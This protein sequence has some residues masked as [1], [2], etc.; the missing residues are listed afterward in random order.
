MNDVYDERID[1]FGSQSS[2]AAVHSRLTDDTS[3]PSPIDV[4]M[5]R[6]EDLLRSC[7]DLEDTPSCLLDDVLF[8]DETVPEIDLPDDFSEM[9][10]FLRILKFSSIVAP[11]LV[12]SAVQDGFAPDVQDV[13]AQL[14]KAS[15]GPELINGRFVIK[16]A[17]GRG[18]YGIVHRAFDLVTQREVALK[19]PRPELR[20]IRYVME[21]FY[22]E[23]TSVGRIVHPG[24]VPLLD[25]GLYEGTPYLVTRLVNGLNLE[26]WLDQANAPVPFEL[27]ALWGEQLAEA[28]DHLHKR[29][30]IHGD[31]KPS[32]ILLEHPYDEE[33]IELPP[34][35]L[36]VRVTDFG[37]ASSTSR[38]ADEPIR[39][40]QGTLSYMAPEQLDTQFRSDERSD[41]YSICVILFELITGR[42]LFD[43]SETNAIREAIR[44]E[45]PP[46]PRS[47]RPDTPYALQTI[48]T[49]G[50]SKRPEDRYASAG[51]LARDLNAW[52]NVRTPEVL[53]NHSGRRFALWLRR[54]RGM[55]SVVSLA[56]L[57]MS[58]LLG[59]SLYTSR[60][61]FHYALKSD[62]AAWWSRYVDQIQIA[63]TFLDGNDPG[64][65]R[66]ILEKL[67]RWPA[68]L[69]RDDDP[70]EFAWFH[71]DLLWRD[72]SRPVPGVPAGVWHLA[73]ATDA[74]SGMVY[75]GGSDGVLRKVD[76]SNNLVVG[77]RSVQKD[78][79]RV[80]AVSPDGRWIAVAGAQGAIRILEAATM[81]LS[82]E[83][84]A[85]AKE[86]TDMA[87]GEDS[88][89]LFSCALDGTLVT[90]E[91]ESGSFRRFDSEPWA[92]NDDD[93]PAMF[94][95]AILPGGK[96]IAVG[97]ADHRIQIY[98]VAKNGPGRALVGH[99]GEVH[100]VRVS[101]DGKWLIST[102]QDRYIAFW[103]IESLE[104]K[105]QVEVGDKFRYVKPPIEKFTD[106]R[107][108]RAMSVITDSDGLNAVAVDVAEGHVKLFQIPTGACLGQLTRPSSHAIALAWLPASSRMVVADSSPELRVWSP[109][110]VEQTIEAVSFEFGR[111]GDPDQYLLSASRDSRETWDGG[112]SVRYVPFDKNS[113][114]IDRTAAAANRSIWGS[115]S[116]RT[117]EDRSKGFVTFL[118]ARPDAFG[119]GRESII[120]WKFVHEHEVT[121]RQF[122]PVLK[123]HPTRPYFLILDS[124]GRI[125]VIDFTDFE[126]PKI[127]ETLCKADY[128]TFRPDSDE[129]LVVSD[130]RKEI[131][132]WN[133]MTE[134][135]TRS[136]I[137]RTDQDSRIVMAEF[138]RDPNRLIVAYVGGTL[139]IRNLHSRRTES[140][141][142]L[143]EISTRQPKFVLWSA[144][145]DQILV[146]MGFG[147]MFLIDIATGKKLFRW[148]VGER[149]I[150]KAE[151]SDDGESL[152]V[153]ESPLGNETLPVASRRVRRFY[154]PR[155]P[156]ESIRPGG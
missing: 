67:R 99:F 149:Q 18:S 146:V 156:D 116:I 62:Q 2:D 145:D 29:K 33:P 95:L 98:Q 23:G 48:V 7:K 153:V 19:M 34:E 24:L 47:I 43:F 148:N 83:S 35:M 77:E 3:K 138:S 64:R 112:Q 61:S 90:H 58:V 51:E 101:P 122:F 16:Q 118:A 31:L 50:L 57:A 49:K 36:A 91:L 26:Q 79:I 12:R 111:P 81:T 119:P 128:A 78:A 46:L 80:L 84:K 134:E 121:R 32:N 155:S 120:P 71:L 60:I 100:Q 25:I 85:H 126:N 10:R 22:R 74:G 130:Q 5:E 70:R 110:F 132:L 92:R 124:D 76:P 151:F 27:A 125:T 140:T 69:Q 143:P 68:E 53:K 42:P 114:T 30:I 137:Q 123:A 20:G 56:C 38:I 131:L 127:Q 6:L 63:K 107:K 133:F 142:Y 150:L 141:I 94:S 28:V 144:D 8:P 108:V 15:S 52:R 13:L 113:F 154:A 14:S 40:V 73:L 55:V 75:A 72:R 39:N 66:E 115:I 105:N 139:E 136:A 152:W 96:R 102:G 41:V 88:L 82:H 87:F 54:N 37:N 117:N 135:W 45:R 97:M 9:A 59:V 93:S 44:D 11:E 106:V 17:I 103:D 4:T 1:E 129:I 147:E 65:V 21:R 104:L 89:N 109:P 86:V